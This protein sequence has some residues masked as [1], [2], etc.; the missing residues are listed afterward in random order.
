[1]TNKKY[2]LVIALLTLIIIGGA[3][4]FLIQGSVSQS[5]DGR[6]VIHLEASEK[7]FVLAEMRSFL[8]SVQNIITGVSENNM[9]LVAEYAKKGGKI[10]QAEVPLN[11]MGKFPIAFKKLGFDT[12]SKFEQLAID[13]KSLGDTQHTLKQLSILMQNCIACHIAYRLK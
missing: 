3:Y 8:I 10:A 13:A 1:M 12:H 5:L 2:W 7:D 11:L 6:T 4:K 9:T